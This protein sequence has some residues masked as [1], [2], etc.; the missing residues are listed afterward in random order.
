M[1][2]RPMN[3]AL[4]G[5]CIEQSVAEPCCPRYDVGDIGSDCSRRDPLQGM[6]DGCRRVF[7][8]L[9]VNGRNA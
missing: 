4:W 5:S 7:R 6:V 2:G 3:P 9:L 1:M 8:W